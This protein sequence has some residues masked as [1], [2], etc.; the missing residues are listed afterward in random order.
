MMRGPQRIG[1]VLAIAVAG[2]LLG[3]PSE[4]YYHYVHYFGRN[5]PFTPIL[6]RFDLNALPNKTVTFF[7]SDQGPATYAPNDTF[8]SVLGEVKQALAAWDSVSTS[9]LRVAFG[10]L[11]NPNQISSTPGGN[12]IFVDLPPGLLGL[13]APTAS[14]TTIVRGV[15]QL[16]RDTNKGAGPSY[17]EEFYTTAVHEIGH[18]LG[19]QHTYTSSAMSQSVVRNTTRARALDAD[20]VAA[21]S[22]LYGKAGWTADYGSISGRVTQNGQPVAMAS[23]VALTPSGPAISTLTNP[24]GT[25]RIDGL[26]PDNYLLYVHPLP[27]DAVA[28]GTGIRLPVDQNGQPFQASG[29]FGAQFYPG[30]IDPQRA[31]LVAAPAGA[32][33]TGRDF[34]VQSRPAA[35]MYD[36]VTYSYLDPASRAYATQGQNLIANTPAY[37]NS[38][39]GQILIVARA[40]PPL[41]TPVPQSVT[42]LGGFGTASICQPQAVSPCFVA[43]GSPT[44]L[45]IY[46]NPPLGAG[47]GPRHMVFTLSNNDMYVL[48]DAVTL[49][50]KSPPAVS[51]VSPNADGSVTI[52][53]SNFSA[54]SRVF[55][56]GL[57]A[58]TLGQFSGADFQGS[59]TVAPPPGSSGQISTITVY[60]PD[61]QNSTFWQSLNPPA[62]TY[63][64]AGPPQINP[65]PSSLPAGV[66]AMVDITAANT[67]FVDGQVTVGFGTDDVAVRR[68]WVL[69]PTRLVANVVV[70]SGAALGASEISV[71]SGFQVIAQPFAFQ[72]QAAN[73]KLPSIQTVV[74]GVP[75]QQTIYPGSIATIRG[76]N[77]ALSPTSV[78]VTLNDV[79]M[80]LQLSGVSATQVSFSIPVGF[81]AGLAILKLNNGSDSAYPV[82]VQIDNPPPVITAVT[83]VSNVPVDAS[84]PASANDVLNV[85]VVGLDPAVIANP[86]RVQVT[87]AGVSM[88]ALQIVAAQGGQFQIQFQL[89][90]SFGGAPVPVA[91]WVDGSS[92][93]VF[94]IT[95]R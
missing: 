59:L 52:T 9:D 11:A 43:Y 72:T 20:D 74:N 38:T 47:T 40:N 67:N 80:Q 4:A 77:L 55:F 70:A 58:A 24:D 69:S 76:Q 65:T 73:P 88:T 36:I 3:T 25:Y 15:V 87:V 92:S 32:A 81:P 30:T 45:G 21:L 49:V 60:N 31:T 93:A 37:I 6:E 82:A 35:P 63:P 34:S 48:P 22:V 14:G 83:N 56:D 5:A 85:V 8:G 29:A 39:Q 42:I 75:A 79:P 51:T 89:Q 90:Q 26:P 28:D 64:V 7:V 50:R 91:V 66:T 2:L 95:V 71:I 94:T 13:G 33:I 57:E 84:H 54:G 78:Q 10:G 68:V 46:F 41:I 17:L 16:S 1:R 12:V 62:Y 44:A 86:S 18:A 27:P 53:G 19:L 61:G 23:V